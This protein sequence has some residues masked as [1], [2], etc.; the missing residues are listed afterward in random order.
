MS[1]R[2]ERW[3]L[4]ALWSGVAA[5]AGPGPATVENPVKEADLPVVHLTPQAVTRLG[6]EVSRVEPAQGPR[7]RTLAGEITAAGGKTATLTAP[8]AGTVLLRLAPGAVVK[9]GQVLAQLAPLPSAADLAAAQA[10]LEAARKRAARN[11]ELVKEGAVAER[12]NDDA[13][14]EL[15]L[16]EANAAAASPRGRPGEVMLPL[17]ASF[18]GVVREVRVADG[19]LVSAGA[20]LLSLDALDEVWVRVPLP[21]RSAATEVTVRFDGEVRQAK[22]VT[23]A[24]P[25]ADPQGGTI[26]A[27]FAMANP[28]GKLRV[29]ERVWVDV[30]ANGP[31]AVATV[32]WSAVAYDVE[33]GTW[34]YVQLDA[35][36]FGRRRVSVLARTGEQALLASGPAAGATVVRV[37]VAELMGVE[38]G[39]GK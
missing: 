21:R 16:A 34:V 35:T 39:A 27:W 10:R 24:P 38:F 1:S 2:S 25:T 8:L 14:A 11:A 37:G 36:S 7:L 33:G 28:G 22:A 32:P 13:Q 6:L 4:I 19:Q 12:A 30:P 26:D 9:R 23:P 18:D 15:A 17:I 31:A 5:A 20:T 29:G 3:L